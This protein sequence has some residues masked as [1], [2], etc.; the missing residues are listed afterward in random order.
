MYGPDIKGRGGIATVIQTYISSA[1]AEF[2]FNT[3]NSYTTGQGKKNLII[4]F[5]SLFMLVGMLI[6][7]RPQLVYIHTASRGSF[8]RKSLVVLCCRIFRLPVI[9]HLHGGGFKEFY[10]GFSSFTQR[11]IRFIIR[12]SSSFV[13]LSAGWKDWFL[14]EVDNFTNI[15]VINNGV[16]ES[17]ELSISKDDK[18]IIFAGRLV[19]GKGLEDLF[20][21]LLKLK[22]GGFDLH[23]VVA[24]DGNVSEYQHLAVKLGIEANVTFSGWVNRKELDIL[25][26]SARC[27]VLPS[28]AEGMPMCILE[29]FANKIPVVATT[30]G[31]IPEML[32]HG[33]DGYLYSPGD[34][35]QLSHFLK[36]YAEDKESA[37]KDGL[38][39]FK[40]YSEQYSE[41]VFINE[42]NQAIYDALNNN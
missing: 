33:V 8:F 9:L 23:L 4:F 11:Y 26:G 42:T 14:N 21:A 31:A 16:K 27:L 41:T 12:T 1:D 28:Y 35:E 15:R 7:R 32:K 40:K 6:F 22:T 18:K 20:Q 19:R 29:A 2:N 13:V 37:I 30:V 10:H 25:M 38:S 24:G 39:G 3:I 36:I 34:I 5:I 17:Q